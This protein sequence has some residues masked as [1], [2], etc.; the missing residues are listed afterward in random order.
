MK[1]IEPHIHMIARTTQDYERMARMHTVACCEPAFWAGYDRASAQAFYDYFKH[2]SEFEPTRAAQYLIQHYC[3]VCINP[4]EAED[5]ELSREVISFLPEFL[6]KPTVLGVGEIGLNLN[7]RNEMTVFAEQAELAIERGL[8]MWIHTP[9]L[10]DKLKGTKMIVEYL[11]G[12]GSVD[13]EMVAFDHVEEHTI[14]MIRDGGYWASM[15]IYPVTKNSPG[16]VVDTVEMFGIDHMMVDASGDWG[17]S[18]PRTLHDAIFEMR[19]RG[20]KE[21]NIETLFYNN[22]CYFL[23]QSGKFKFKPLVPKETA[24]M[25][26][27]DSK[28]LQSAA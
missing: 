24:W 22:P 23:G 19:R 11:N 5:L 10:K 1:V 27:S 18:D 14:K 28:T 9:H 20:H 8:L 25:T 3:Y 17:P 7:T 4:K 16:R 2:I 12:H 15:T 26:R 13:P 21:E 6:D